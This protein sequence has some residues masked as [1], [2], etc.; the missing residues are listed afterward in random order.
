MPKKWNTLSQYIAIEESLVIHKPKNLCTD[1][2]T[3]LPLILLIA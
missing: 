2:A 3:S 1:E